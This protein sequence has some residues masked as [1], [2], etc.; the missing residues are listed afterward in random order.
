MDT[1]N[2]PKDIDNSDTQF[3]ADKSS[4][5]LPRSAWN[6]QLTKLRITLAVKQL[7]DQQER[8]V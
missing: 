5:L 7:L 8:P 3:I 1:S 4:P 6:S 2:S